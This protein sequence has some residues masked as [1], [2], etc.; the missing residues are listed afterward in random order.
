MYNNNY[1]LVYYLIEFNTHSD[2]PGTIFVYVYL[3]NTYLFIFL[4]CLILIDLIT[5]V[6]E[7]KKTDA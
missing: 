7:S 1:I 6:C 5:P 2:V 3:L 4:Y